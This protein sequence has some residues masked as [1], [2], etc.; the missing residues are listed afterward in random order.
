M[1]GMDNTRTQPA[2]R[3]TQCGADLEIPE[4]EL[5]FA[6][7]HCGSSLYLDKSQ[8]VF[9]RVVTR[10]LSEEAAERTLHRWMAGSETAR[11]LEQSAEI[12]EPVL[13][14]FP[15]WRFRVREKGGENIYV[16]PAAVTTLGL[17]DGVT[18]P[19]GELRP[20]APKLAPYLV[21]PTVSHEVASQRRKVQEVALVHVPLFFF[22]YH[23][24]RQ[25]Y[26]AA[27]DGSSGQVY[28]ETYP[29]RWNLPYQGTAVSAF[30]IFALIAL[31]AYVLVT[32]GS[33]DM[34]LFYVPRCAAQLLAAA[35]LF[36]LAR[37]IARKA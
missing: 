21:R 9:H 10:T 2:L 36:F 28:A 26:L 17:L 37:Q 32:P 19:P 33:E 24:R 14:Y 13:R 25:V 15:L 23:Y 30:V 16:E 12:E 20:Y 18:I 7:A 8:V 31:I 11:A 22:Q 6:C 29:R 5:F 34:G 27:V 3:C 1:S 4:G 35:L